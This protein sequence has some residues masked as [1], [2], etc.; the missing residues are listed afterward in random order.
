MLLSV[1]TVVRNGAETISHTI[2]SVRKQRDAHFEH[3]IVDGAST[4]QT[5]DIIRLNQHE[6]LRWISE[7]D[8]GIYDAMNKG[9]AMAHGEWIL[10]LGADDELAD[11]SVLSDIFTDQRIQQYDL[12]CGR[13][14]FR[15]GRACIPPSR[16]AG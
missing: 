8:R 5:L 10:F 16:R 3:I 12:I 15:N 7:P 14:T 9:I 4:D 1:I 11:R 6:R 13:S 2:D